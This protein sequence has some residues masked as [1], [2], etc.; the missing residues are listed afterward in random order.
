M[1]L[2]IDYDNLCFEKINNISEKDNLGYSR[3]KLRRAYSLS[4]D[5]VGH[6]GSPYRYNYRWV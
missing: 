3:V 4:I 2:N 1:N 6:P 5:K